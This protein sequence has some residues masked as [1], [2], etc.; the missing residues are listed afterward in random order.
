MLKIKEKRSLPFL[1][2]EGLLIVFTIVIS[3]YPFFWII[4]SSFKTNFEIWQNPLG[5]TPHPAFSNYRTA[6]ELAPIGR[7]FLNSVLVGG[8]TIFLIFIV[9]GLAGY[10]LARFRF[11]FKSGILL[12]L[13][14]C[15]L[16]PGNAF[17]QPVFKLIQKI[18]LYDSLP[19]LI[20]VYTAFAFPVSTFILR[21]YFLGIPKELEE[22][23]YIDGAG[24]WKTFIRIMVPV[25]RPAF[26]AVGTLQFLNCWN[27]FTWALLLTQSVR[28][29][30]LP[31]ALKYFVATYGQQYGA[32]FAA[33]VIVIVPSLTVYLIF[34]K[35][36]VS[37]L[38]GGS[39]KG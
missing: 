26:A 10:A 15:L 30:T 39:V 7:F 5:F 24:Y 14:F 23:A 29:R 11:R 28:S 22:A 17:L 25:A 21:G 34:Q 33:M 16:I 27:E 18:H 12:L 19:A 35:Q 20:L 31:L 8:I 1:L 6:F 2:L 4:Q 36:I 13:G 3:V 37:G 9:Y 32:L 38:T